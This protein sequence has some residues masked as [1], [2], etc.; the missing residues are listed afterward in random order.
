MDVAQAESQVASSELTGIV[1]MTSYTSSL[2]AL[3]QLLGLP[4]ADSIS[5]ENPSLEVA[6]ALLPQGQLSS[7]VDPTIQLAELSLKQSELNLKYA[8][9]PY[10]PTVSFSGGYGTNYSSERKDYL[11]G[12]YMPFFSQLNQNRNLNFGLSLSL[13]VFDAFKTK[14]NINRLKL[15]LE[16]KQSELHKTK[17]ER[18]KVLTLAIQEYHKSVKEYQVLQ[19]Q[20]AALETNYKAMKERYDIGVTTAMEYNKALLDYNVAESNVIKARYILMYNGVVIK[21]LRGEK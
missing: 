16:N 19:V 18:E 3:K 5:I 8:K 7:T 6:T 14:N 2:I 17:V 10:Y 9:G 11:T 12:A 1:N 15:D 20:H 4:L 21:V 13:P